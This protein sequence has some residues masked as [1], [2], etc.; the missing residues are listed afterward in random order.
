LRAALRRVDAEDMSNRSHWQLRGPVRT[1]RVHVGE[2]NTHDEAWEPLR[3]FHV[4]T[5]RPDGRLDD[6]EHYN[7]DG[8]IARTSY[9][10]D[11]AGR[12]LE[13][14]FQT[15][16]GAVTRTVPSYDVE[17][18]PGRT[19][20]VAGAGERELESC[21]YD[22]AGR[23]TVV[24]RLEAFGLV[25]M[26]VCYGV[27][28]SER[29]YGA[30]G[31]ATLSV[32]YDEHDRSVDAIFRD[33]AD[34]MLRRVS[35][36]RDGEGRL[37]R[38]DVHLGD[39]SPFPRPDV[40]GASAGDRARFDA[41]IVGSFPDGLFSSVACIY[42]DRGYLVERTERMGALSEAREIFRNDD[43]GNPIEQI[44]ETRRWQMNMDETGQPR[45]TEESPIDQRNAF[46]Y[47]YDAHDNWTERIVSYRRPSTG[48]WQRTNIERRELTYDA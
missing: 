16:D 43:R 22:A 37:V 23:R 5:F 8:T 20:V 45:R 18:R 35:F 2:W 32:S 34:A 40:A 9:R 6:F 1:L 42:D 36:V 19:M 25:G 13:T 41:L 27:D 30:P 21:Y 4:A 24:Q 29:S 46:E 26:N 7:P 44:S 39:V 12:L 11:D 48:H 28:G 14:R 38:E 10:Y 3:L 33:R 47:V 17:G 31:A 15:G